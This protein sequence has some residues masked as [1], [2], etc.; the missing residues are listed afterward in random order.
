MT[1]TVYLVRPTIAQVIERTVTVF[2]CCREELR[3]DELAHWENERPF[4]IL[5]PHAAPAQDQLHSTDELP[6]PDPSTH[7]P[8]TTGAEGPGETI[9]RG[10]P[11]A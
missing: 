4:E 8:L 11:R 3:A 9:R 6:R 7:S 5:A 2:P 1:V 10:V